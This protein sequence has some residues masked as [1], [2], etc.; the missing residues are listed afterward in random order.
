MNDTRE[1]LLQDIWQA[2]TLDEMRR[3]MAHT[4]RWME[5]HP[6]DTRIASA[7]EGLYMLYTAVLEE[8]KGQ[9]RNMV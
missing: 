8:R 6:S 5:A 9:R 4:R 1:Q 2:K 7:A 3:V